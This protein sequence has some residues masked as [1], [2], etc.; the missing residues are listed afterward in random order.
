M[1]YIVSGAMT[2]N[3]FPMVVLMVMYL[4]LNKQ[5][6]QVFPN[7][8]YSYFQTPDKYIKQCHTF[9]SRRLG[10]NIYINQTKANKSE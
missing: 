4:Y 2:I 8:I 1:A 10:L 5:G 3:S 6:P 9:N 7:K